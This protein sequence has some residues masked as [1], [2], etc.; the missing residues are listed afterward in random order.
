MP[1]SLRIAAVRSSTLSPRQV[2]LPLLGLGDLLPPPL[3]AVWARYPY[4]HNQSVPT[5][6][7]M[8]RPAKFRTTRF[9]LG[10]DANV[11]T[12]FDPQCVG[13][14]VGPAVPE[15]WKQDPHNEMDTQKPGLRNVGHDAHLLRADGQELFDAAQRLDLVAF[16][17]TL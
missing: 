11:K 3:E 9:W 2:K 6:C 7:E 10:P 13:L 1:R 16:L 12:D 15:S 4:L 5:L 17:K 8:L 14:P